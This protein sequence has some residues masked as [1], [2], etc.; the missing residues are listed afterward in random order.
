MLLRSYRIVAINV[1]IAEIEGNEL[2]KSELSSSSTLDS[3]SKEIGIT[4]FGPIFAAVRG[5]SLNEGVGD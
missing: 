5:C 4:L 3:L 1:V 2:S